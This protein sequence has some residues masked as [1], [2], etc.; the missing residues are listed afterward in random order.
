MR[1]SIGFANGSGRRNRASQASGFADG[2]G[3]A[4]HPSSWF[5]SLNRRCMRPKNQGND[6]KESSWAEGAARQ[7]ISYFAQRSCIGR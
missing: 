2:Y 1:F 3:N 4:L 6:K 5:L 7:V